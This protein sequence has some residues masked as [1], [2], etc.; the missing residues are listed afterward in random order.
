MPVETPQRESAT[1]FRVLAAISFCH[2]SNDMMQSVLPAVYPILK[3]AYTLDF[4]QWA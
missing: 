4:G 1:A 2:L 3:K